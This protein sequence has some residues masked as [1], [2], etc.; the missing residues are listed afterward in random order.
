MPQKLTRKFW[1]FTSWVPVPDSLPYNVKYG[2]Y[3]VE[4]CPSTGRI[5]NQGFFEC[6][7]A[8]T[9]DTVQRYLADRTA[10]VEPAKAGFDANY[11]YCTKP[12][13]Y[14]TYIVGSG[15]GQGKRTDLERFAE[16]I[17]TKGYLATVKESPHMFI[18][19]GARAKELASIFHK[20]PEWRDLDV[21]VKYGPT[22]T[23]KTRSV[24]QEYKSIYKL[25]QPASHSAPLYFDGYNGES[26]LLID[27]FDDWIPFR[28]MLS[29]LDGYPLTL[30]VRYGTVA[31]MWTTVV[32]TTNVHPDRWY[33][34]EE[35]GPLLRRLKKVQNY[36]PQKVSCHALSE[37]KRCA[38]P[39]N[40][41]T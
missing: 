15:S 14:D 25:E 4:E 38:N 6:R 36:T 40:T 18:K 16:D 20:S 39:S 24:Y 7:K 5:H 1:C 2:V 41:S 29:I 34:G 10:H 28:R 12:G 31:A 19:F 8:V 32:I 27:E 21:I 35:N 11:D 3:S 26:T 17:K 13:A 23:G 9:K 33:P 37:N 30:A 22:G